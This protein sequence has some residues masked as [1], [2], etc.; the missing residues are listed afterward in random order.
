MEPIDEKFNDVNIIN[1]FAT[2]PESF[3]VEYYIYI[4]G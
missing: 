4:K 1:N 2:K 3:F